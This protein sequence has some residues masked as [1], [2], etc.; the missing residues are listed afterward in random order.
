[1]KGTSKKKRKR[2]E[3]EDVKEEEKLLKDDRGKFL[4][5]V[6]KMRHDREAMT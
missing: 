1:L 3:M 2:S 6:K 4:Q 5:Q